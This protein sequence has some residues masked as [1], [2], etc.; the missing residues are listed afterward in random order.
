MVEAEAVQHCRMQVMDARRLI[1]SFEPNVISGS[2]NCSALDAASGQ[3]DTEA[4]VVM[5]SSRLRFSV[6]R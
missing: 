6:A 3:P 4:P 2:V 1:N 5:V